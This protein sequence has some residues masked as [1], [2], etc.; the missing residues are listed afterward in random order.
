MKHLLLIVLL[1]FAAASC[2]QAQNEWQAIGELKGG[3]AVLTVDKSKL[4]RSYNQ[5]ILQFSG[6]NGNFTDVKI[7]AGTQG[8]Y[9]LVFTGEKY[10]ST[11]R[12]EE[13]DDGTVLRVNHTISCTTSDC[14]QETSGCEPRWNGNDRGHCSPCS[15]D[16][17]C[18]K[19]VTSGS[20]LTVGGKD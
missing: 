8:A 5:N 11:F 14:S 4:L 15:N 10:K 12:V 19:T 7:L 13:A 6:I 3:K 20:L 17:K 16:G 1:G 2:T 18:T 9:A